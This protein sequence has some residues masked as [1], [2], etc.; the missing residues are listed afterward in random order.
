MTK[1]KGRKRQNPLKGLL[2]GLVAGLAASA[3]MDQYWGVVERVP[4]ARP[5]QQPRR[6]G[7]QQKNEPSTQIIADKLAKAVTGKEVP[8]EAKPAAGV[9]V[10]YITGA[11][12]G[13][14]FGLVAALRPRTGLFAGLL[15]GVAI[16]LFLD[17]ITLRALNIAPDP[18]KVS[19]KIHAEALGA[20]LVYG[21]SLALLTRRF[22]K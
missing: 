5:E 20:H 13:S 11:L 22:L 15:Y 16:W 4:G 17:E 1:G 10:H 14:V 8:D 19:K 18:K 7:G 2:A 12:Q 21:G 3:V 6:G 9:A